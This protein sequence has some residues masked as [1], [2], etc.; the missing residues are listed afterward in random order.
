MG[1]KESLIYLGGERIS[2][3]GF[4]E[5]MK[6]V[7]CEFE[8]KRLILQ[9][10]TD[11]VYMG[12][13]GLTD[14]ENNRIVITH[15]S[16]KEWQDYKNQVPEKLEE[17]INTLFNSNSFKFFEQKHFYEKVTNEKI[18]RPICLN[19]SDYLEKVDYQSFDH[20]IKS[21]GKLISIDVF[22]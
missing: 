6:C 7:T 11:M 20:Y 3:G 14:L 9:A 17:R 4:L 21:G 1:S 18:Y 2:T 22:E 8:S 19:C 10:D 16:K 5:N 12:V 13:V 15:L